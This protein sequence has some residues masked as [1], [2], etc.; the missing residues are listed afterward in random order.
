MVGANT[1]GVDQDNDNIDI[2]KMIRDIALRK[3]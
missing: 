2:E 1:M 3:N